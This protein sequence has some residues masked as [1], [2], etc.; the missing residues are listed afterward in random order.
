MGAGIAAHLAN[1]GLQAVLL[2]IVP[3]NLSDKEKTDKRARNKFSQGGL[4]NALKAR[5]AAFF[6]KQNATLVEI[7]NTED[8]LNKL[9]DCDLVIEA[10]IEKLD[11]KQAMFEKLEKIL[12]E[13]AIVASNTMPRVDVVPWS[14]TR[15]CRAMAC[16][17]LP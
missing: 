12:P 7:G 3:P 5:P 8:D 10:I 16:W 2:D 11:V 15:M 9:N 13:H 17:F 4:D 1:A 6:T 14:M